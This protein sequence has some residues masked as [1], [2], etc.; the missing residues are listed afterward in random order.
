[1]RA[2]HSAPQFNRAVKLARAAPRA[3]LARAGRRWYT[4]A[5]APEP[6]GQAAGGVAAAVRH[7]GAAPRPRGLALL[8]EGPWL[9]PVRERHLEAGDREAARPARRVLRDVA[10]LGRVG[11]AA[12]RA[13]DRR[14]PARAV[15]R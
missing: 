12:A 15:A 4:S 8:R 5:H 7:D 2:A 11:R 3:P 9:R 13:A 6:H 10:G 1:E 14:Q